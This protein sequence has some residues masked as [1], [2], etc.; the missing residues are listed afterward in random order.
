M[1]KKIEGVKSQK[2]VGDKLTGLE[3]LKQPNHSQ[4]LASGEIKTVETSLSHDKSETVAGI[5]AGKKAKYGA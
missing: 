3:A 2:E 1:E 5:H 4:F